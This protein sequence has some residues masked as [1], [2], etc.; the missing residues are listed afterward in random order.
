MD[1]K[2]FD[3]FF[4]E[5]LQTTQDFGYREGD[6]Q[7]VADRLDMVAPVTGW[8][9]KKALVPMVMT[10]LVGAVIFLWWKLDETNGALKELKQNVIENNTWQR[11]TVVKTVILRDTVFAANNPR[12]INTHDISWVGK[13][14]KGVV[15]PF[16][17]FHN[18]AAYLA[19]KNPSKHIFWWE[20]K[21]S[22]Q[23]AAR[24]SGAGSLALWA[25]QFAPLAVE[26]GGSKSVSDR[27]QE[28]PETL[29]G[30]GSNYIEQEESKRR[31]Y[32]KNRPL[33]A[34]PHFRLLGARLGLS[35]G[36]SFIPV[37]DFTNISSQNVGL[38]AEFL[39]VKN[40]SMVAGLD[41]YN[42]SFQT[43][44]GFI[45]GDFPL[46]IDQFDLN[47][48]QFAQS[49]QTFTQI[50]LGFKYTLGRDR[51]VQPYV[52]LNYLAA[53]NFKKDFYYLFDNTIYA[54]PEY[55]TGIKNTDIT[56]NGFGIDL[57]VEFQPQDW[58]NIQFE[59]YYHSI[60][61]K[62]NSQYYDLIGVRTAALIQF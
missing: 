18:R 53:A 38:K 29:P 57:G 20:I 23:S 60:N 27:Y 58:L 5:N 35:V 46:P 61:P 49:D 33:I 28:V 25:W 41:F 40:L 50:K 51:N 12:N 13:P 15:N 52:G 9:W 47:D 16:L 21:N 30:L 55:E 59:T 54:N 24:P 56:G 8:T 34:N 62:L 36:K 11:D 48:L 19:N 3:Q 26:E 4:S 42:L 32:A 1:N 43:Q 45:Q 6:W 10:A 22:M 7:E 17:A 44:G 2:N 14:S 37:S 31:L 39:F